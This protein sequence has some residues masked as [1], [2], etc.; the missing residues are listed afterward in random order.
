MPGASDAIQRASEQLR[1]LLQE[2]R[3]EATVSRPVGGDERVV[4][5]SLPGKTQR[6]RFE[7][8]ASV[9]P[10]YVETLAGLPD[11][12]GD[13]VVVLVT[14]RLTRGSFDRCRDLD[15]W[16]IDLCGN[17]FLSMPGVYVER[18]VDSRPP[19]R[20]RSAG[21]AFTSKGSRIV[22]ALLAD[23]SRSWSQAELVEATGVSS[24]Y[25]STR[26]RLLHQE[27]YCRVRSDLISVGEPD[28]LLDD[29]LA[30]YR[31]DRHEAHVFAMSTA[32]YEQGLGKLAA[33]LSQCGVRF[34]FTGWSGAFLRAPYGTSD[35]LMAYVD[36]VPGEQ[37][38]PVLHSVQRQGNV[39]LFVPQDEGVF[40]F[41]GHSAHGDVVSDA[42]LFLDLS[43][44][45]GRA[46]EQA[47]VLRE[48]LLDFSG[49]QE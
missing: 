8:T 6:L 21:T 43:K 16:A 36:R 3:P 17:V 28:R 41:T 13:G 42:Q 31:F 12:T 11:N 18:Y 14:P 32:S 1:R 48:Q 20:G 49:A 26:V 24:G 5:V 33:E 29:W 4:V 22:R 27:G 23:T 2:V 15:V 44:M 10:K 35:A 7:Y 47:N 9:F 19:S 46:T 25:V 45:P 39:T 34:A 40:Q 37:E 38:C 30:A